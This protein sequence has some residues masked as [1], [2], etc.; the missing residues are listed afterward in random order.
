MSLAALLAF[1]P[2]LFAMD[3]VATKEE[4]TT[5]IITITTE[6]IGDIKAFGKDASALKE[7]LAQTNS[8]LAQHKKEGEELLPGEQENQ[9]NII[10]I[11]QTIETVIA[12][13]EKAP[14]LC[15]KAVKTLKPDGFFKKVGGLFTWSSTQKADAPQEDDIILASTSRLVMALT[16]VETFNNKLTTIIAK[17][18]AA[19]VEEQLNALVDI[20]AAIA[21]AIN[22]LTEE[23]YHEATFSEM[24]VGFAKSLLSSFN[25]LT[26]TNE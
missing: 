17:E 2:S 11:E 6:D 5:K 9:N 26:S 7:M 15:T 25:S 1:S 22:T 3:D 4:E 12:Q 24:M 14:A 13:L 21:D 8:E 19:Q 20:T 10:K 23:L 16:A 18:D